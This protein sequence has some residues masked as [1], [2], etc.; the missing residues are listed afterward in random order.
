MSSTRSISVGAQGACVDRQI[1]SS[2]TSSPLP[3]PLP[4]SDT[5]SEGKY[6][7]SWTYT[8]ATASQDLYQDCVTEL[9]GTCLLY[10]TRIL[11]RLV[12]TRYLI[13]NPKFNAVLY[14]YHC[15][16]K[17]RSAEINLF[18]LIPDTGVGGR[19]RGISEYNFGFMI[20]RTLFEQ[21]SV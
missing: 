8:P 3:P 1:A 10:Y 14:F 12:N 5:V 2:D 21:M 16:F 4:H 19:R 15:R 9:P 7:T 6:I 17:R 20:Q 18:A 11:L 13:P